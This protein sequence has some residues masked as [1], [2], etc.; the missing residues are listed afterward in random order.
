MVWLRDPSITVRKRG[1]MAEEGV[2]LQGL[3]RASV[4]RC[5]VFMMQLIWKGVVQNNTE[6]IQKQSKA[7]K[8]PWICLSFL[9]MCLQEHMAINPHIKKRHVISTKVNKNH[10]A[11]SHAALWK[12]IPSV[13]NAG[14][15]TSGKKNK[16]SN[17]MHTVAKTNVKKGL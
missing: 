5:L 12:C 13:L 10:T 9:R 4:P 6:H 11:K 15:R 3:P 8:F 7:T 14:P 1:V 16:L 2:N 17:G